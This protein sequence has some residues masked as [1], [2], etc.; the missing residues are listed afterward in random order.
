MSEQ[1]ALL[2]H[3][4]RAG[5]RG[6]GGIVLPGVQVGRHNHPGLEYR[7][8]WVYITPDLDLAWEYAEAAQGRGKPKVLVVLPGSGLLNDDSTIAG[9]VEQISFRCTHAIVQKVLTVRE[10]PA[11]PAQAGASK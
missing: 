11:Q 8:D 2:Y 5:F 7:S 4:T 3:G 1:V 10:C 6:R 9:G